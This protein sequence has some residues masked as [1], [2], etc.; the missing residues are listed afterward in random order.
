MLIFT[1]TS[2]SG[3]SRIN[4]PEAWAALDFTTPA[5]EEWS[6]TARAGDVYVDGGV[7]VECVEA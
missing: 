4:S 7:T 1:M 6:A 5:Y 3:A 2:W